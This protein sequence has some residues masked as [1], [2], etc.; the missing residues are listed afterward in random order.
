M[1][2]INLPLLHSL[3]NAFGV[4]SCEQ[5]ASHIVRGALKLPSITVRPDGMGNTLAVLH[6]ER[7]RRVVLCAHI[8]EVGFQITGVLDHGFLTFRLVG[9]VDVA[10]L[11]GQ[12]VVINTCDGLIEGII[13]RNVAN[14]NC[15]GNGNNLLNVSELWIDI[16]L[17]QNSKGTPKVAVGDFATF[18]PNSLVVD[19][20]LSSKA[21][22]NRIGVYVVAEVLRICSEKGLNHI[23]LAA[24]FTTQ[25]EIGLRGAAKG[26]Q[27]QQAESI[28]VVDTE[29]ATD[30]PYH[31]SHEA[32]CTGKGVVMY[33][34]ADSNPVLRQELMELAASQEIPVQV[35]LGRSVTG[36]TDSAR[37]QLLPA[38]DAVMNIGIP[39]RYVH[40]AHS[41]CSLIDVKQC[42]DLLVEFIAQIDHEAP[43]TYYF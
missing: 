15:D 20:K 9:G 4:S 42:I 25:E 30:I 23:S 19:D 39:C 17:N 31:K 33:R 2:T 13:Q 38:C 16:N 11:V 5:E 26:L 34:N 10:S 29:N 27:G 21:V 3:L 40:T 8:D 28:I 1:E 35:A 22:D 36:G 12:P 43:R 7:H 18:K 6:E 41:F 24:L 37:L 14:A 32:V